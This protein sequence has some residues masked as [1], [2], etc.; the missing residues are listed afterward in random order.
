MFWNLIQ[1]IKSAKGVSDRCYVSWISNSKAQAAYSAVTHAG[2]KPKQNNLEE[3]I[4]LVVQQL[5][6]SITE[7]RK[8]ICRLILKLT[9]GLGHE[10]VRRVFGTASSH[11]S[12]LNVPE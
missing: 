5:W 1:C 12:R 4:Q 9:N 3:V 10:F 6:H 11:E 7:A 8:Q 2:R